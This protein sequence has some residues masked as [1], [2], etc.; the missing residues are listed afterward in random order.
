MLKILSFAFFLGATLSSTAFALPD[1]DSLWN[2]D[3]VAQ[4]EAKFRELIP[5]AKASGNQEYYL[6]LLTQLAR[7]QSL[8]NK[9]EEAHH[10]L[11]EV[12]PALTKETPVAQVRYLLERGRTYN[13]AKNLAQARPLFLQAFELSQASSFDKYAIDAA[14]MMAIVEVNPSEQLACNLKAAAIS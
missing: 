7:T 5:A 10:L 8:Q 13:S 3:Q 11:D 4:T 6:Q 1:F 12:Q 2:F 14:H 9:F